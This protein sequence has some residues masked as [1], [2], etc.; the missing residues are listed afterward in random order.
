MFIV[1]R[2]RA[3][4]WN[5]YGYLVHRKDL[6]APYS[7]MLNKYG[8]LRKPWLLHST[9]PLCGITDLGGFLEVGAGVPPGTPQVPVICLGRL[10]CLFPGV[11]LQW[12]PHQHY[13]LQSPLE[14]CSIFP[15]LTSQKATALNR[16]M[17]CVKYLC[18]LEASLCVKVLFH[19][20]D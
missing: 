9:P 16:R 12:G 20:V 19:G 11:Y 3:V 4:F 2:K 15:C 14:A 5:A 13:K 8:D 10:V 18:V 7:G 6:K 17:T 1:V